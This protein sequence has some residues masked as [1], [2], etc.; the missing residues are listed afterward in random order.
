MATSNIFGLQGTP[1]P[2]APAPAPFGGNVS[3]ASAPSPAPSPGSKF[4][5]FFHGLTAQK[6][7]IPDTQV[8][9]GAIF[10]LLVG[11]ACLLGFMLFRWLGVQFYESRIKLPEVLVKPPLMNVRFPWNIWS[12]VCPIFSVTDAELMRTAG[13]DALIFHRAFTFGILFFTPVTALALCALLPIYTNGARTHKVQGITFSRYTMSNLSPGSPLYWVPFVFVIAVIAWGQ[14]LLIRFY[15]EYVE[16]HQ[17]Y[18]V[19]GED[20]LNEWH[21]ETIRRRTNSAAL[22]GP[23]IDPPET[24]KMLGAKPTGEGTDSEGKEHSQAEEAAGGDA[25]GKAQQENS[26]PKGSPRDS[27]NDGKGLLPKVQSI[28]WNQDLSG[29]AISQYETFD[30][31]DSTDGAGREGARI[32]RWWKP[33]NT[34]MAAGKP[35]TAVGKPPV[36]FRKVVTTELPDGQQVTVN[37]QQYVVLACDVPPPPSA[38]L[39]ETRLQRLWRWLD[40]VSLFWL[41]TPLALLGGPFT[42]NIPQDE[43]RA[44][45]EL[46]KSALARSRSTVGHR[47]SASGSPLNGN[48]AP[49]SNG[50][51]KDHLGSGADDTPDPEVGVRG[52]TTYTGTHSG[53]FQLNPV[54]KISHTQRALLKRLN[55]PGSP[56]G[57]AG[58]NSGEVPLLPEARGAPKNTFSVEQGPGPGKRDPKEAAARGWAKLRD[59][60]KS[61]KSEAQTVQAFIRP[62]PVPVGGTPKSATAVAAL[63]ADA[64]NQSALDLDDDDILGGQGLVEAVF[65]GMFEEEFDGVMPI[66]NHKAVDCLLD[67]WDAAYRSLEMAEARLAQ[68]K[69]GKRPTHRLGCCGCRGERVDSINHYAGTIRKL[70][71]QI[72][73]TKKKILAEPP[74]TNSYFVFFKTQRAAAAAAQCS[75]FPEGAQDAFQ[76]FGAPGPE[77]VNWQM[78]WADKRKRAGMRVLGW[79]VLAFAVLFPVGIFTGAVT[80]VQTLVCQNAAFADNPYCKSRSIWKGIMTAVLPPLLLTLWQNMCMPQLVYRGAQY[81]CKKP[82]LSGLDRQIFG[83]FFLWGFISVL[84]GGIVGGS[85]LSALSPTIVSQPDQIYNTIGVALTSSANFFI[86]YVVFQGFFL[87]PYRIFAPTLFPILTVL[88]YCRILPYPVGERAKMEAWFPHFNIRMGCELGRTCMLIYMVALA[89]AASSPIILPFALWW[90]IIAWIFWRYG[91]LYVFERSTESGGMVWHQIFDKVNWCLFIFGIFTGCCLITNKAFVSGAILIVA[92]PFWT[93]AFYRHT[94]ER[95]GKERVACP[96]LLAAS[97]PEA[98]VDR[99]LYTPPALRAGCSGWHPE[100]GKAWEHWGMPRYTM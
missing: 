3:I 95:F 5:D 84:V 50:E 6:V 60:V 72:L 42:T 25:A 48:G 16:L 94:M 66:R 47:R 30:S 8:A 37:A 86:N 88:R 33:T 73:K 38:H 98:S 63:A 69:D 89:N 32:H 44:A 97:A 21:M 20:V 46:Q 61:A 90:F 67:K 65:S 4:H 70:E 23:Y 49:G 68:A 22:H 14:F 51:V 53:H 64:N 2:E 28:N 19:R 59:T 45:K 54:H 1:S 29:T 11:C 26:S 57:R 62:D 78:L 17:R 87:V 34:L 92:V 41:P 82:S 80:Q 43:E 79:I 56:R 91:I 40:E 36:P 12:W 24:Q 31:S 83:I 93:R 100:Y 7:V 55:S 35:V 96:L 10:N 76:V 81:L 15:K 18:L 39:K 27:E 58:S 71:T 13:L 99:S 75:I 52:A 85:V 77:E 74:V 9:S